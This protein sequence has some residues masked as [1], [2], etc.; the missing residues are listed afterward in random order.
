MRNVSN[1]QPEEPTKA[2][3]KVLSSLKGQRL[4]VGKGCDG[5]NALG[6]M[7]DLGHASLLLEILVQVLVTMLHR[8]QYVRPS[9]QWQK[10]AVLWHPH[11]CIN[12]ANE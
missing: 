2:C 12:A 3:A 4:Q 7:T 11:P 1:V 5:C 8:R 9:L 6:E 10:P